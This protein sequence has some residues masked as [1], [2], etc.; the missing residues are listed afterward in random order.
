MKVIGFCGLPGSGKSTAIESIKDLGI[1]I[2]MGD[3]IRNEAKNRNI[4]LTDQNL[5]EIA[6]KLREDKG[7][8]IIAKKCVNLIQSKEENVIFID[9]IRSW[10]EVKVFKGYW[11]FPLI[12]IKTKKKLR[13]KR[14]S[15]RF[16]TDDPKNKTK[17]KE[18]DE[19]EIKFGLKKVI[20][21]ADF[22]ILNNSTKANLRI[23]TRNLVLKI[24]NNY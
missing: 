11:K 13:Y 23:R 8:D 20:K 16:R 12:A 4:E 2:T 10:D 3:V 18:R 17:I 7:D 5:G 15:E 1:I 14:I 22:K 19:R 21:N 9:G 6:K 24:I